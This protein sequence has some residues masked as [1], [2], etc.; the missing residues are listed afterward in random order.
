MDNTEYFIFPGDKPLHITKEEPGSS[1][2]STAS[3]RLCIF[4]FLDTLIWTHSVLSREY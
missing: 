2:S 1:L 3:Y 4:S